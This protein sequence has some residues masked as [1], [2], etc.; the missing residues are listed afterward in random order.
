M[1]EHQ[2]GSPLYIYAMVRMGTDA[3]VVLNVDFRVPHQHF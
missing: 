1:K 2:K 3:L